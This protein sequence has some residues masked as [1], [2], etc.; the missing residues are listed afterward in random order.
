M[1]T[2]KGIESQTVQQEIRKEIRQAISHTDNL[3]A[4]GYPVYERDM[5][6]DIYDVENSNSYLLGPNGTIYIIY[7]YG[8]TSFTSEKDI[9]V[10]K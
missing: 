1:L 10:I 3:S 8:N 2:I 4:L 7:A 6:N 5:T 9:V